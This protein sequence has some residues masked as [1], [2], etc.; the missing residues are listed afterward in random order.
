MTIVYACVGIFMTCVSP[1]GELPPRPIPFHNRDMIL[2]VVAE[3][4]R[5][6]RPFEKIRWRI[7]VKFWYKSFDWSQALISER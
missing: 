3:V 7:S 5:D 6:D 1:G 2:P 4:P